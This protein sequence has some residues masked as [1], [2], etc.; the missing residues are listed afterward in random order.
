MLATVATKM[1]GEKPGT[2]CV[3]L[4]PEQRSVLQ[5]QCPACLSKSPSSSHESE[6]KCLYSE[7][8][9]QSCRERRVW[10]G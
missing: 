1:S 6:I 3:T 8:H 2:T 5:V 4:I 10:S 9:G 7:Q